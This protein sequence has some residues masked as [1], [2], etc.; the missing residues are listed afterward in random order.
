MDFKQLGAMMLKMKGT[1]GSEHQEANT[2][3]GTPGSVTLEHQNWN[4]R[5]SSSDSIWPLKF[6]VQ[7]I[8]LRNHVKNI[9]KKEKKKT[10]NLHEGIL[11]AAD[12]HG[13]ASHLTVRRLTSS[14][15]HFLWSRKRRLPF[16][17]TTNK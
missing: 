7:K 2:R 14:C 12:S 11:M 13:M 6:K 1:P 15:Q 5:I 16:N 17:P 9:K 8:I 3:K 10:R 4:V